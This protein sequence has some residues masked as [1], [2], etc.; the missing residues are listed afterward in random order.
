M[1]IV[2]VSIF[3][4][5][6]RS[7]GL[8]RTSHG[9]AGETKLSLGRRLGLHVH[10][11]VR[12]IA[13]LVSGRNQSFEPAHVGLFQHA[14]HAKIVDQSAALFGDAAGLDRISLRVG[15]EI[16]LFVIPL[17]HPAFRIVAAHLQ[18]ERDRD[19]RLVV[20]RRGPPSAESGRRSHR[21][22]DRA[23]EKRS[24]IDP[25]SRSTSLKLFRQSSWRC[26][27]KDN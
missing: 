10:V 4:R 2:V 11:V 15:V 18:I 1:A 21:G 16:S 20:E 17:H 9:D 6:I 25:A 8:P 13:E 19:Q 3:S 12:V 22:G 26:C 5:M 7:I 24:P 14:A 27:A 23:R